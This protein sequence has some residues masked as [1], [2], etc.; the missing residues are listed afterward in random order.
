MN[1]EMLINKM[2]I[3]AVMLSALALAFCLSSTLAY[4]DVMETSDSTIQGETASTETG[5][6]Q[7]QDQTVDNDALTAQA[8]SNPA[9]QASQQAAETAS[10]NGLHAADA[11]TTD[12]TFTTDASTGYAE[13]TG[14]TG[15]LGSDG[16]LVVPAT[17]TKDGNSYK[18]IVKNNALNSLKDTL[19]SVVFEDGVKF[20][21]A[22]SVFKNFNNLVS[23]SVQGEGLDLSECTSLKEMFQR[24]SNLDTV[25]LGK[26]NAG[27]NT[28]TES[29]FE[30]CKKLSR[31][32]YTSWDMSKVQSMKNM[33]HNCE[34]LTSLDVSKWDVSS[35]TNLNSA[36]YGCKALTT[37][38][39]S[40]WNVSKVTNMDDLFHS[41]VSL[42]TLDVSKWDVSNVS[43]FLSTFK[44]CKVLTALDVSKWNLAN[45]SN[46]KNTF[47]NCQS[48]TALDVSNWDVSNV[49]IMQCTFSGCKSLNALDV[50]KWDVR[51]VTT[52][53]QAF[54]NLPATTVLDLR[55]WEATSVNAEAVLSEGK[56]EAG[57]WLRA[58]RGPMLLVNDGQM[59]MRVKIPNQEGKYLGFDV[60]GHYGVFLEDS[61]ERVYCLNMGIPTPAGNWFTKSSE[62]LTPEGLQR[63]AGLIADTQLDNEER[64]KKIAAAITFFGN[65]IDNDVQDALQHVIWYY[66]DG[67]HNPVTRE[68]EPLPDSAKGVLAF[69]EANWQTID[70]SETVINF[71]DSG[72]NPTVPDPTYGYSSK[73]QNMIS[74]ATAKSTLHKNAASIKI[75]KEIATE[76]CKDTD[77]EFT[78]TVKLK[79]PD[80]TSYTESYVMYLRS[81]NED[82]TMKV[83]APDVNGIVVV[84]IKGEGE[85]LITNL[86]PRATYSITESS[87]EGWLMVGVTNAEGMVTE[88][89]T[90]LVKFTN[91]RADAETSATVKKVWDDGDDRDKIRPASLTVTLSNGATVTL[92]EENGWTATVEHLPKYADGKAIVYTWSEGEMPEGYKLSNTSVNGTVTTL[93]NSHEYEEAKGKEE[94][95]EE[96]KAEAAKAA[97]TA[98]GMVRTGDDMLLLPLAALFVISL[99]TLVVIRRRQDKC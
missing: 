96:A 40:K 9:D 30:D 76:S 36:F 92:N 60:R 70:Y 12:W 24:C 68:D 56:W 11:D 26:V 97:G 14:Y 35:V 42:T 59:K 69:V 87:I 48:L 29:M 93:T 65:V 19:K 85:A 67:H 75:S 72:T 51:N 84:T 34:N 99:I 47:A 10:Q 66:S 80:G 52:F 58:F 33:F 28:S 50:S 82:E 86:R 94:T 1:R 98:R 4:A 13:I 32:G 6:A 77:Q 88:N 71:Y 64:W 45:A 55:N 63:L 62:S 7:T 22:T 74:L 44:D 38:D 17:V 61:M 16:N 18:T 79:N 3:W 81:K 53:A 15:T 5:V 57:G 54:E 73:Y 25:E 20:N 95:H 49:K 78:F 90:S 23:V 8:L 89:T 91:D 31:L 2:T 43:S 21:D 83:A 46:M 27:S 39:V 37:L 41:C